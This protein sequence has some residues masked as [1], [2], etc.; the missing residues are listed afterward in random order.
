MAIEFLCTG[1]QQRL[2][3]PDESAGKQAKCPNCSSILN[4]PSSQPDPSGANPQAGLF[5]VDET[6]SIETGA[7]QFQNPYAS[8]VTL[9]EFTPPVRGEL[10]LQQ[11][12][13]GYALTTAWRLFKI[14]AALLIVAYVIQWAFYI[15]ITSIGTVFQ[16]ILATVLGDPQS[17]I[18]LL[19][20]FGA[21]LVDQVIQFWL[22]IGFLRI[23]LAVARNEPASIG[24]LFSGGPYILFRC[25]VGWIIFILVFFVGFLLLIV[26]GIYIAL[27][28]WSYMYFIV[29]R[30]CGVFESFRLA[31]M[32]ASG[33]RLNVLLLGLMS[34]GLG[35]LGLMA[36]GVGLLVTAPL[37][38]LMIAI[39]YL[40]MTGQPF[41][42]PA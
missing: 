28:Y 12:D 14:S 9:P 35:V 19:M 11:I 18:V 31:G 17:P 29:D 24:M 26:P 5:D 38:M 15:G 3:V 22:A 37:M 1:C 39:A 40:M 36:C 20:E 34:M 2:S 33:N 10:S 25:I 41:F 6:T 4:I 8:P 13:P 16:E 7:P 23:N 30:D 21:W 42:Q 27:T 32:H